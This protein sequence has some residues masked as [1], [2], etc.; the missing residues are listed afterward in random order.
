MPAQLPLTI[1]PIASGR[2][3]AINDTGRTAFCGPYVVSAIT[4]YP[5][6]RIEDEIRAFRTPVAH[7]GNVRAS[8]ETPL[9]N[10]R[11]VAPPSSS[12]L[13][14]CTGALHVEVPLRVAT[15]TVDA[16]IGNAELKNS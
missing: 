7:Q 9:G 13:V 1:P 12:L 16:L 3:D 5:I 14:N 4:G 6:S 15:T 10:L 8:A 2:N 11:V